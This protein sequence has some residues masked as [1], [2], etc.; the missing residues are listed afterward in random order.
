MK[1]MLAQIVLLLLGFQSV[2]QNESK[3]LLQDVEQAIQLGLKNNAD[4]NLI[5]LQKMKANYQLQLSTASKLPVIMATFSGQANLQLATT[6]LP[7]EIFGQPG[8][9]IDAQ[10]GKKYNYNTGLSLQWNILDF[11]AN[12]NI[13]VARLNAEIPESQK[14]GLQQQVTTLIT[15]YYYTA[16]ISKKAIKIAS[17]DLQVLDSVIVLTKDKFNKGLIDKMSFNQVLLNKLN[18][19]NTKNSS[20]KLLASSLSHLRLLCGVSQNTSLEV[21]ELTPTSISFPKVLKADADLKVLQVQYDLSL[22]KLAF[23]KSAHFPKISLNAYTGKQ[24]YRDDFGIS[25][26]Q[27][28]WTDYSFVGIAIN[29]PIF[30][31]TT[32][33]TKVKIAKTE[34]LLAQQTLKDAID[35]SLN[36][37]QQLFDEWQYHSTAQVLAYQSFVISKENSELMYKKFEQ[38]LVSLDVYQISFD[39]YLKAEMSYLNSLISLY[40]SFATIK[41][42]IQ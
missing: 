1:G 32:L 40:S 37:D 9:S 36:K 34:S 6:P 17:Q 7:G 14:E 2:A 28:S 8:K 5:R 10:F 35:K 22:R 38:G 33:R 29:V 42:R 4:I 23:E 24:Q 25:F 41:S 11:Q 26:Q 30:M 13:E 20:E 12:K 16:V 3:I 27:K 31:G 15:Q 19:E 18:V 39:N 21:A